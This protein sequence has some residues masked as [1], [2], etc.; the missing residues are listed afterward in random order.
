M[1]S[2]SKMRADRETETII[3]ILATT[4]LMWHLSHTGVAD[5]WDRVISGICSDCVCPR[6]KR[7]MARAINTK[8]GT[9]ILY[10][11]RP[12]VKRSRL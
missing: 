10:G 6:S 11:S 2:F 9:C 1:Y 4:D 7:K 5:A 12:E 3:A 8:L